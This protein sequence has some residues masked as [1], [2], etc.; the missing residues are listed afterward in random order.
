MST[1]SADTGETWVLFIRDVVAGVE[2]EMDYGIGYVRG[3]E[4][5]M[6]ECGKLAQCAYW[7]ALFRDIARG[8][9]GVVLEALDAYLEA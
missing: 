8:V 9:N 7:Y 4:I 5:R 2:L 1:P 3:G 6:R